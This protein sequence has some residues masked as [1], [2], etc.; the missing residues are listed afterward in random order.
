VNIL[1]TGGA[2]YIGSHA[3]L[4]LSQAGHEVV[5]LDNFCNSKKSVLDR[6]QKIAG[7]RFQCIEGD[8]RDT[9]L[10]TK[11]LQ[12]CKIDAAIHLAGLKSVGESVGRPI[13]YYANN[14]QGSISLLEAMKSTNVKALVFS[15][16]ATVYGDPLY[17]PVDENHPTT[18][19]NPYGRSKL[20]IEEILKDVANADPDL[21]IV[22]LRYFNPVGAH[23]SGLIG[24]EPIG[25]PNNLMPIL[26]QVAQ[27]KFSHLNV[28]GSNYDTTDGTGVRDYIHV[29]DLAEGHLAAL[30]F[31][32]N[33][34]GL[35]IFNLGTGI[36]SS[37]LEMVKAFEIAS[38]K[39]VPLRFMAKRAGDVASCYAKVDK[40]NSDLN[41]KATR[42]LQT[43]CAS[44]LNFQ[45][46]F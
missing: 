24:E 25:L 5:I 18:A 46:I 4:V 32:K 30:T 14:V 7:K 37:V 19:T 12:D 16:S 3:A 36:G 21:K 22:C 35:Y 29:M 38:G 23:E 11:T 41:W 20:H 13:E 26:A 33:Q 43:I 27:G 44:I 40:A 45:K 28:Y 9:V 6:L 17:L 10:V 31:L 39:P 8:V 1:L 2:G 34:S 42:T 15:S